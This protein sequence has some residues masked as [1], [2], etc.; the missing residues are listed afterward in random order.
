MQTNYRKVS[1]P[2]DDPSHSRVIRSD[3]ES[4]LVAGQYL[5]KVLS[6]LSR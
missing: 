2:E 3:F 1:L 4:H 5:D 6:H